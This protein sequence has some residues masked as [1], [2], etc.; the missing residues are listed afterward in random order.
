MSLVIDPKLHEQFKQATA[1]QGRK[2]T[3]VLMEFIRRYV[4]QH[5]SET[6]PKKGG[7]K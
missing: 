7:R 4:K 6:T 2:M 5:L 3:H 1:A